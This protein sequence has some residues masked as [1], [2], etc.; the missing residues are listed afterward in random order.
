MNQGSNECT[1]FVLLLALLWFYMTKAF[2]FYLMS[3]MHLSYSITSSVS[4]FSLSRFRGC[5]FALYSD[6]FAGSFIWRKGSLEFAWGLLSPI[7]V[8]AGTCGEYTWFACWDISHAP[9]EF[10]F[11]VLG[12]LVCTCFHHLCFKFLSCLLWY[13]SYLWSPS[14]LLNNSHY[15]T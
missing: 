5:H 3:R 15:D 4:L 7:V 11:R 12:T 8:V 14:P 9:I 2:A 1:F 6:L 13:F 10:L